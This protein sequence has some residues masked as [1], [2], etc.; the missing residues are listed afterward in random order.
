[1]LVKSSFSLEGQNFIPP[2]SACLRQE[3]LMTRGR[4]GDDALP[5]LTVIQDEMF[6][7]M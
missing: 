5:L 6:T 4:L 3:T 7:C 2:P 1:M